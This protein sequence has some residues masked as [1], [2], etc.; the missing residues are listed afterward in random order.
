MRMA[1]TDMHCN[2]VQSMHGCGRLR[3]Q[4]GGKGRP[5]GVLRGVSSLPLVLALSL[6]FEGLNLVNGLELG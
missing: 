6:H 1:A 5:N 4:T 2:V 3:L